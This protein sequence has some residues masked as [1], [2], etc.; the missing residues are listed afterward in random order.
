M[1][2]FKE[3]LEIGAVMAALFALL[4]VGTTRV[5]EDVPA[6]RYETIHRSLMEVEKTASSDDLQRI[7]KFIA[8]KTEDGKISWQEYFEIQAEIEKVKKKSI[9]TEINDN[10]G[11]RR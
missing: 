4:R 6:K 1:K 10:D 5:L 8:E 3:F 11:G 7:K 9:L 2:D